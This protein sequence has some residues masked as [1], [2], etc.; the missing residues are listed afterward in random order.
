MVVKQWAQLKTQPIERLHHHI[1]IEVLPK[2]QTLKRKP[3]PKIVGVAKQIQ[4]MRSTAFT[5]VT[6]GVDSNQAFLLRLYRDFSF[7][8]FKILLRFLRDLAFRQILGF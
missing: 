7:S 3:P 6:Q 1:S 2:P 4:V 5:T 8:N